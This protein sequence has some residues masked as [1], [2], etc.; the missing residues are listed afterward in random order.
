MASAHTGWT[1]FSPG[2]N[3]KIDFIEYKEYERVRPTAM[4][5]TVKRVK[6]KENRA[7]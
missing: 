6:T 1:Q 3:W 2:V 4:L 7:L 5:I